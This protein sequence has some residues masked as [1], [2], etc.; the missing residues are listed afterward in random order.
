[1]YV[2]KTKGEARGYRAGAAVR[3]I[4]SV[5]PLFMG[6]LKKD[7]NRKIKI[8]CKSS[9]TPYRQELFCSG[10]DNLTFTVKSLGVP[11]NRRFFTVK[12]YQL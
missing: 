4:Y 1:M 8:C 12:T 10:S 7:L 5:K 11:I 6:C 2:C 9:G 3:F